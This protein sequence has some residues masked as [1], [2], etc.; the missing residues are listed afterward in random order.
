MLGFDHVHQRLVDPIPEVPI[1]IVAGATFRTYVA[2]VRLGSRLDGS[3][4]DV[5]FTIRREINGDAVAQWDSTTSRVQWVASLTAWEIQLGPTNT[6]AL[7]PVPAGPGPRPYERM[8]YDVVVDPGGSWSIPTP[9]RPFVAMA[10]PCRV[11]PQ[12]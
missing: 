1:D 9:P 5:T 4:W 2:V 10:G 3:G 11:Y 8:I 12:A 6:A 7:S